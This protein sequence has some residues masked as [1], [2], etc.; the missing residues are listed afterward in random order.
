MPQFTYTAVDASGKRTSGNL[1][2]VN[3]NQLI[4]AL[5]EQGLYLI[6]ATDRID[7]TARDVSNVSKKIKLKPLAIFCRQFS[8]LINAGI[9]AIKA[10][11]I[12]YQQAED[13]ILKESIGRVYEA[14]QKGEAM[15]DAFRKQGEAFPELFINM[16]MTGESSGNLDQVL[17]RMADHYEKENKMKNKIKGAM[18]YPMVLGILTVAVV[19]L[20]LVVV[21]PSFIGVIESGGGE[22]P[23]PTRILLDLS[24][25]IQRFWWLLGGVIIL[26]VI[27]WRGFK[28]SEKG[29]LWWDGFKL[30]MP[31]VGKS[32][33]MIYSARFARTLSTLVSSGLQMLSAIEITARVVGNKLIHDR[34]LLVTEDIRKGA[35]LSTAI[36]NTDQFPA[37]IYNMISVGEESGL[38]DDILGKTAAFYD[39]ESDAAI[40]RLV[41]LLEPLMIIFMAIIIGFIVISIAL[42]MFSMYGNIA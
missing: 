36:R 32:L 30:N 2:A 19:I 7:T 5:K 28:R 4:A 11:D 38:L 8:T 10:L 17:I 27:G 31:I 25:F 34:L 23:L 40:G 6:E 3:K 20:M 29:H 18:I 22:I 15:S 1:E 39:E 33:R 35:Q 12:L 42:P 16:I 21:L 13:K 9:T 14:V 24:G 41:G 26:L 37:M